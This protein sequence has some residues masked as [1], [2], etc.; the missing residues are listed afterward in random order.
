MAQCPFC[1]AEEVYNSGFTIECVNAA[2][3]YF[4]Q[5]HKDAC[6]GKTVPGLRYVEEL[7]ARI[8]VIENPEIVE[9]ITIKTT[10][11]PLYVE[12]CHSVEGESITLTRFE[13]PKGDRAFATVSGKPFTATLTSSNETT[14]QV[15]VELH[16]SSYELLYTT[17]ILF[18]EEN[19]TFEFLCSG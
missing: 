18:D 10:T 7:K 3:L 16:G 14:Y 12:L 2:C 13:V 6:L 8:I 1:S 17:A 15:Q 11:N 5:R 9:M 4:S 19:E